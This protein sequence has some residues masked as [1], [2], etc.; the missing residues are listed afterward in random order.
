MPCFSLNPTQWLIAALLAGGVVGWSRARGWL[1]PGGGRAAFLLGMVFFGLGG[2]RWSLGLVA[3]FFTSSALTRWRASG[4]KSGRTARQ[5]LA[6]GL[7]PLLSLVLC[8]WLGPDRAW[9]MLHGGLAVA[10][11]D[12]WATEIGMRSP[13][14]PYSL[15]NGRP[16]PPG[17]SGAVSPWG[18]FGSL[19]GAS[20]MAALAVALHPSPQA[21][22]LFFLFVV[23]GVAGSLLDSLLGAFWQGRLCCSRCHSIFEAG[24]SHPCPGPYQSHRGWPWLTNDLVN[25]VT[26]LFGALLAACLVHSV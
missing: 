2:W 24:E 18:L 20:F 21:L 15:R 3:F 7:V 9:A 11:A 14:L 5:V 25:L 6:N 13:S 23:V 19:L 1:Q 26:I 8:P 17:T 4:E 16:V 22:R 12:T 10:A